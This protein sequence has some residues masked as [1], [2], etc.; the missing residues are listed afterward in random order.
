MI[1]ILTF[2]S[3]SEGMQIIYGEREM[4]KVILWYERKAELGHNFQ[5]ELM[6]AGWLV[7]LLL[8]VNTLCNILM[9]QKEPFIKLN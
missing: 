1:I 2:T 6:F 5:V 9:R 3:D 4:N 7:L 8:L